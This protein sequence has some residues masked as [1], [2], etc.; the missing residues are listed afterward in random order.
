MSLLLDRADVTLT[1]TI[2]GCTEYFSFL[3]PFVVHSAGGGPKIWANSILFL[4]V[5]DQFINF[6][7]YFFFRVGT[8]GQPTDW[9]REDPS[10]TSV[11]ELCYKEYKLKISRNQLETDQTGDGCHCKLLPV[12]VVPFVTQKDGY[13]DGRRPLKGRIGIENYYREIHL[14]FSLLQEATNKTSFSKWVLWGDKGVL[15]NYCTYEIKCSSLVVKFIC[16]R[17]ALALSSLCKHAAPLGMKWGGILAPFSLELTDRRTRKR[18]S[19]EIV[20]STKY[21]E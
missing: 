20:F 18:P 15:S 10:S 19:L 4:T 14:L 11:Q 6:P 8:A 21:P 17:C 12:Y 1:Q 7:V 9:R 16:K 13:G 3:F 2:Y 5:F